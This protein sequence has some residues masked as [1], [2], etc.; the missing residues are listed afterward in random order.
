MKSILVLLLGLVLLAAAAVAGYWYGHRGAAPEK[1][2]EPEP[3]PTAQVT[4]VPIQRGMISRYVT[5]YGTVV[6][7]ASEV[8]AVSVPYESRITRMLAMPGEIVAAGTPLIELEASPATLIALEDARNAASAARRD[9]ELVK[10]RFEQKLATSQELYAAENNSRSAQLKLKSLQQAGAGGP[11]QIKS[12][13]A[14]VVGKINVQLGQIVA[15]GTP[16]V[17]VAGQ[18]KIEV[19]LAADP[20][21]AALLKNGS[22]VRLRPVNSS[23]QEPI[24]GKVRLVGQRV[25]PATRRVDVMVSLPRDSHLMLESY[26]AGQ[27]ASQSAEGLIV[28]RDAVLPEDEQFT[29]FSVKDGHAVKHAVKVGIEN[30]E[31]VQIIAGDLK[32]GEP[33][34]IVGN[35][36]LEDGMAVEV[37][38]TKSPATTEAAP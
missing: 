21:D 1:A 29:L 38:N 9:L 19:K 25:D 7:P 11:Q 36:E 6:A 13:S 37:K 10:G 26:V 4:V 5:L 22:P 18:D 31:Q 28:P 32:E 35:F 20:Q 8:R 15:A 24:E 14:G 2:E 17:E 12:E 16:L 34:V 30:D 27:I 23:D 3:K 33:V